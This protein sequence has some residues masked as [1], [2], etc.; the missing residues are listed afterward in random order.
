MNVLTNSSSILDSSS[1]FRLASS[2]FFPN[3]S[4]N[5]FYL[6]IVIFDFMQLSSGPSFSPIVTFA[7]SANLMTS[8]QFIS[9]T[10]R[11]YM[12]LSKP[13]LYFTLFILALPFLC[14]F[15]PIETISFKICSFK[16]LI[17]VLLKNVIFIGTQS[18]H[19]WVVFSK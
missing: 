7:G 12:K 3:Q 13:N 19:R 14:S 17:R 5:Y 6:I 8:P 11:L 15:L 18:F 4:L 16:N 2:R 9:I 1:S 10:F